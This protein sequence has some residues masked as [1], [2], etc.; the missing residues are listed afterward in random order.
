MLLVPHW[1]APTFFFPACH[2]KH[3]L[4]K[5]TFSLHV[6]CVLYHAY[7][8]G[9]RW[10]P[11]RQACGTCSCLQSVVSVSWTMPTSQ[12]K[13]DAA[14]LPLKS[15][16]ARLLVKHPTWFEIFKTTIVVTFYMMGTFY[17]S[18]D[19]FTTWP[20]TVYI[21]HRLDSLYIEHRL[22]S[23]EILSKCRLCR[24]VVILTTLLFLGSVTGFKT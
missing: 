15:S 22:D 5:K 18:H 3:L 21:L 16:T 12:R 13:L 19:H 14:S 6:H 23:D 11:G 1:A 10:K 7:L 8:Y 20:C 17:Q 4:W 24:L 9:S 2:H